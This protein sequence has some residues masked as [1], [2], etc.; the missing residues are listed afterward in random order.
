MQNTKSNRKTLIIPAAGGSTRYST[1]KPK[2]LLTHPHGSLMIEEVVG[3]LNLEEY[4]E[5][6]IVI[7]EEHCSKYNADV[8]LKQ[9]FGDEFKITILEEPTAS[10]P[11]TVMECVVRNSI[12]GNIIIKDCDCLV[13]FDFP[14]EDNFVVSLDINKQA[15]KNLPSKSFILYNQDDIIDAIIEKKVVSSSVCLGVYSLDCH[16]F[17]YAFDELTQIAS[18]NDQE[19]YFSHIVSYLIG[20]GVIFTAT[21][22]SKFIDWGTQQEWVEYTSNLKTYIFDIDGVLLENRGKYG[23]ETWENT[24]KPIEENIEVLKSLSDKGAEIIFITS[25][26]EE[27]LGQFKDYLKDKGIEYKTIISG[28]NHNR[29]IIVNDFFA[30]NPFPSCEAIN[31]PRNGSLGE[32]L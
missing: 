18:R 11:E 10:A 9:L 13:E 31:V 22:A 7:L 29:R 21:E 2:W 23:I 14:E 26:T 32:Y 19:L 20:K 12:E 3:A 28:C 17:C 8:I 4:D 27:Y 6:H 16:A 5:K 30:T 25:R 24:F 15:V 1:K